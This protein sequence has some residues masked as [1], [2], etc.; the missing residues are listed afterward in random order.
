MSTYTIIVKN[1]S[2]SNQQY[3]LFSSPPEKN[4]K[5]GQVWSNVWVKTGGTPT[6]N[7]SQRIVI[8]QDIFA[9]CGSSTQALADGVS[10]TESDFVGPVTLAG[11]NTPGTMPTM[12]IVN[13]TPSFGGPPYQTTSK[14][15]SFGIFAGSYNPQTYRR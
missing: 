10:I 1:R 13:G 2:T 7:G 12:E 11:D 6:P 15:N 3:L 9:I 4:P 8:T 5:L 14:A